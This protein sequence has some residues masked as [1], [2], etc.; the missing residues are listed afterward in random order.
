MD[1][2]GI[3]E[4]FRL[5]DGEHGVLPVFIHEFPGHEIALSRFGQAVIVP[6]VGKGIE[7]PEAVELFPYLFFFL[8]GNLIQIQFIA[9]GTGHGH[10]AA[11]AEGNASAGLVVRAG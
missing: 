7:T 11:G 3:A 10:V 4:A 8:I 9:E 1:G 6:F 5:D 2:N